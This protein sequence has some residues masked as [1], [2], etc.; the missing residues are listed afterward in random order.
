MREILIF[1]FFPMSSIDFFEVM[2]GPTLIEV[3]SIQVG[4]VPNIVFG[5][6]FFLQDFWCIVSANLFETLLLRGFRETCW[7]EI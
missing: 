7:V 6:L 1:F 2:A 4:D 5:L 3:L